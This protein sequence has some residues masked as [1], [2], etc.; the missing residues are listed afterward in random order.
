MSVLEFEHHSQ[1]DFMD[2]LSI[3]DIFWRR[4]PS[5]TKGFFF[6]HI[7]HEYVDYHTCIN[8]VF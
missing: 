4:L 6:L 3:I 2:L 5:V 8:H 7:M 1:H